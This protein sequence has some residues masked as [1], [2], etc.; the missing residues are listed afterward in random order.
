MRADNFMSAPSKG[1]D[2][3]CLPKQYD[4]LPEMNTFHARDNQTLSYRFYNSLHKEKVFILLHGS[5]A[6]GTYLHPLAKYLSSKV[7]Q[8]FVPNLRGHYQSGPSG[9]CS[10]IEQLED[11]ISDIILIFPKKIAC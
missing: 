7:G 4:H 2:F 11:D 8:V 6:E 10:Y 5:S 9:D 1:L 3:S